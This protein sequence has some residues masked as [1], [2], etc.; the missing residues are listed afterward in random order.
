MVVNDSTLVI[1]ESDLYKKYPEIGRGDEGI[2]FNYNDQYAMKIFTY[3]RYSETVSKL[4]RK[5]LKI[6]AM[7]SLEDPNCAFPLRFV[8]TDGRK[9][10]GCLTKLI[11]SR[12]DLKDFTDLKDL[13]DLRRV[14]SYLQEG[15]KALQR[16]HQKGIVI[17]DLKG[18][19][20]LIDEENKPVYTD[21][22]NFAYKEHRFDLIPSRAGCLYSLYGGSSLRFVD[23]DKLLY[24]I[25]ALYYITK[26]RNFDFIGPREAIDYALSKLKV[27]KETQEVLRCIFSDAGDKPYIGPVLSKIR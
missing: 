19:N 27:D 22:D 24:A 7:M 14:V 9:I 21:S 10:D 26:D 15:D 1:N 8:S 18:N 25:M 23:N 20:I 4:D 16:L 13:R 5:L 2:V 3:Y 17:G 6:Q 11:Q 12:G